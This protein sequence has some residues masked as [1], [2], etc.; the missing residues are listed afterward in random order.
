MQEPD[1]RRLDSHI[2]GEASA[3]D[4]AKLK[5]LGAQ[6]EMERERLRPVL[7]KPS[8]GFLAGDYVDTLSWED[9]LLRQTDILARCRNDSNLVS[10]ELLRLVVT[11]CAPEKRDAIMWMEVAYKLMEDGALLDVRS[12]NSI[13][14][15]VALAAAMS[16]KNHYERRLKNTLRD[17]GRTGGVG[18][19]DKWAVVRRFATEKLDAGT[20]RSARQASNSLWGSVSEY[21]KSVGTPMSEDSGRVTLYRWFLAHQ[22][23]KRM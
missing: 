23:H 18:R 22:K 5:V 7:S 2:D 6:I 11:H 15:Q 9:L 17:H 14:S 16:V 4:Q 10:S 8:R 19:A 3:I 21:A 12:E 20:W 13:A 1:S